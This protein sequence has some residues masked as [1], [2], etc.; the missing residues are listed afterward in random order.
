VV[1]SLIVVHH[2]VE[3]EA[4]GL[5]VVVIGV[6]GLIEM[7]VAQGGKH[8]KAVQMKVRGN[9]ALPHRKAGGV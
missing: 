2:E 8:R 9:E 5:I 3:V 1:G 7:I 4:A 6:A